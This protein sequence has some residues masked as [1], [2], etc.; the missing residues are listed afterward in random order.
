MWS[1]DTGDRGPWGFCPQGPSEHVTRDA[2]RAEGCAWAGAGNLGRPGGSREGEQMKL[3]CSPGHSYRAQV[4]APGQRW[5]PSARAGEAESLRAGWDT[6]RGLRVPAQ[7]DGRGWARRWGLSHRARQRPPGP[8]RA[9]RHLPWAAR[10]GLAQIFRSR[11]RLS[12]WSFIKKEGWALNQSLG[13][14]RLVHPVGEGDLVPPGA[15]PESVGRSA[16]ARPRT[17]HLAPTR[18]APD[19][20]RPH[21]HTLTHLS[22][23]SWRGVTYPVSSRPRWDGS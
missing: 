5:Q 3:G 15:R 21:K 19:P 8:G 20:A 18:V 23:L 4:R 12:G 10:S 22:Q 11:G 6:S 16:P 2:P 7:A 13:R 9:L 14:L 1:G 17:G